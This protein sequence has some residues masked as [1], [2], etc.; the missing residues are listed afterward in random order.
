MLYRLILVALC[1]AGLNRGFA[2]AVEIAVSVDKKV[3][4][5]DDR[6]ILTAK[7]TGVRG[8]RKPDLPELYGF[9]V[10][11]SGSFTEIKTI[12]GRTTMST[13]YEYTLV[14][15]RTGR[16]TIGPLTLDY[17]DKAYETEP[18]TVD[19]VKS[20]KQARERRVPVRGPGEKEKA[21]RPEVRG[22]GMFIEIYA[23]RSE[24]YLHEQ[25]ILTFRFCYSDVRLGKQPSYEA[26]PA[27]GFVE[28][29]LGKGSSRNYSQ[30]IDGRR[31]RVSEIKTALFPYQTG[32][33]SIGPARLKGSILV[34]SERRRRQRDTFFDFD[35]FFSDPFFGHF[36][37]KP[38]ELVSNRAIVKVR[39]LPEEGAPEGE[40]SVGSYRLEVEAKPREVNVGDPIT[41]TMRVIGEGDLETVA[42]PRVSELKDFKSY[43][44]TSSTE[45][46][47]RI[48]CIKGVKTFEQAIVP[49]SDTIN[50]VPRVVFNYFNPGQG[51]YV[52][53]KKGPIPVKVLPAEEA[54][55]KIVSL[56]V[57]IDKKGV[58]LLERNIVFIKTLPGK[59]FRGGEP[60][61]PS[62]LFWIV[63]CVP[64]LLLIV[65]I[66]HNRH[67]TRL[68]SDFGYARLR[69]AGK[70]M[71]QRLSSVEAALKEGRV[72]DFYGGLVKAINMYVADRLNIPAGGLTPGIIRER[73]EARGVPVELLGRLGQFYR[74]S[75]IARFA[76][77]ESS[78]AE[79]EKAYG[80]AKAILN[81][82]RK[83]RL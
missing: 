15:L 37:K 52:T 16:L 83:A 6:L 26:P 67:R 78:R 58:K 17:E 25:V 22:K 30:V 42:P 14:P 12:N 48:N 20:E 40:V 56:P 33:L 79:M 38:F 68:R 57:G 72:E 49:L 63:Q 39:P 62:Y 5:M 77:A 18:I 73:L 23:D 46:T 28:R 64:F 1:I 31:Y 76:P 35:D 9:R 81:E 66:V 45:I 82:L 59:M 11:R 32:E 10:S 29:Q 44:P 8:T 75:D 70:I 43:E 34:A 55:T 19:V 41:L 2:G 80:E 61:L 74:A 4:S 51:R 65:A 54:A 36:A 69:S 27:P 53:L 7:I 50:E 21:A 71:R 24:V 3:L 13:S 60:A 47:D